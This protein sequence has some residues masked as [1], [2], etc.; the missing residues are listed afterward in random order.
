MDAPLVRIGYC[1]ELW[2]GLPGGPSAWA[3]QAKLR[4]N[5]GAIVATVSSEVRT[6]M[7][8]DRTQDGHFRCQFEKMEVLQL[9][10][11]LNQAFSFGIVFWD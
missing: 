2:T 4:E 9:F 3:S 11:Q 1:R 10:S 8:E 5:L 7:A 6:E